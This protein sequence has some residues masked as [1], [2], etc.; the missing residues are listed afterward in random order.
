MVF[1]L[2]TVSVVQSD[3]GLG[4]VMGTVIVQIVIIQ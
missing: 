2:V 3:W 1:S 4:L